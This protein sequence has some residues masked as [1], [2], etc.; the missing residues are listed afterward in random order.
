MKPI[1]YPQPFTEGTQTI[2]QGDNSHFVCNATTSVVAVLTWRRINPPISSYENIIYI[3]HD[4]HSFPSKLDPVSLS[5]ICTS[6]SVGL[7]SL[8]AISLEERVIASTQPSLNGALVR[9]QSVA[10]VFCNTDNS[11]SGS[12]KCYS[13]DF[14]T[15]ALVL[16]VYSSTSDPTLIIVSVGVVIMIFV[17]IFIVFLV[18]KACLKYRSIKYGPQP[19]WPEEPNSPL[20][21][22]DVINPGYRPVSVTGEEEDRY[23]FPRD[24]L[25]LG[26]I[27]GTFD[28][29]YVLV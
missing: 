11:L 25:Q 18:V 14:E 29:N 16:N 15:S 13:S 7:P 9:V 27:L 6:Y 23:E 28:Y 3:P 17:I 12:Y 26:A 10:L 5:E 24:R 21:L 4:G 22:L 19:M 2:L 20:V 1:I 8:I